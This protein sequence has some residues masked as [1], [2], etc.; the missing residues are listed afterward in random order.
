M[1][2]RNWV[3][4]IAS[5][6]KIS[7]KRPAAVDEKDADGDYVTASQEVKHS[8]YCFA[9]CVSQDLSM[10]SLSARQRHSSEQGLLSMAYAADV[11]DFEDQV[12]VVMNR[13]LMMLSG[14]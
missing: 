7:D 1:C 10:R 14:Q 8:V 11:D 3:R 2:G 5:A 12:F 4:D 6:R 13:C 9:N